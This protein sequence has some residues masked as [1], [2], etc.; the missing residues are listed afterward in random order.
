MIK[1]FGLTHIALKVKDVERSS[2]FYN[3]VFGVREMYHTEDFVQVQTP[4]SHD[5]IVFEQKQEDKGKAGI[6]HFGFRLVNCEDLEE[7]INTAEKAGGK[8][9][10]RGEFSPGEPYVFLYDP[11]GN[12]VEIWYEKLGTEHSDF[13]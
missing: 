2:N 7:V 5:I 3:Q 11:D 8:V 10:E 4:G 6:V 12:E 9:K 1:T 13:N